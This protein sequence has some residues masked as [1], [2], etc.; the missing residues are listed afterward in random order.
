MTPR[1]DAA[2]ADYWAKKQVHDR[3]DATRATKE[4]ESLVAMA[5]AQ[6]A[7]K[8]MEAARAGMDEALFVYMRD[9]KS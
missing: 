3:A 2:I 9:K 1:L 8:E 7:Q 5:V 4:R 6:Q